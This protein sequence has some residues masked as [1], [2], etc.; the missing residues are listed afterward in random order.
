MERIQQKMKQVTLAKGICTASYLSKIEKNQTLPSDEMVSLLLKRLNV[1]YKSLS[2]TEEERL[3]SVLSEL[4]KEAIQKREK[5]SIY[6]QIPNFTKKS[7]SFQE[8]S[9]FYTFKLLLLRILMISE[10]ANSSLEPTLKSLEEMKDNFNIHQ[11]FIFNI[12][13]GL[14]YYYER[15]YEKSLVYLE[16]ALMLIDRFPLEDWE[17]ADFYNAL[18][19]SYLMNGHILNTI[20]YSSKSLKIFNGSLEFARAIDCYIVISIAQ[21]RNFQLKKAEENLILAKKLAEKFNINEKLGRIHQNLGALYSLQKD[22]D[23]AFIHYELNIMNSS[24]I[25]SYLISIFSIIQEYSKLNKVD[26]KAQWCKVG[27]EKIKT[28]ISINNLPYLHHFEIYSMLHIKGKETFATI[29]NGIIYFEKI[30]DYRHVHKY[31]LVLANLLFETG[32][33]KAAGIYYQKS[34]KFLFKIKSLEFWEE[35]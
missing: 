28:S 10:E 30:K 5:D 35:L 20:E 19:L 23:K 13:M 11:T 18:S 26:R 17:K 31:S 34:N 1:Q 8:E 16:S 12:N 33:Y 3:L 25:E 7:Y 21:K 2:L 15:K 24:D 27:I 32:Q 14:Y 22:S 29:K 4:Y 9:N 6:Q